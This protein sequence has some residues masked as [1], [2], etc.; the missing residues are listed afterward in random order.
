MFLPKLVETLC[1]KNLLPCLSNLLLLTSLAAH[2]ASYYTALFCFV[3]FL[4]IQLVSFETSS[5]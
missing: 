5:H 1:D 4:I 2:P 3:L